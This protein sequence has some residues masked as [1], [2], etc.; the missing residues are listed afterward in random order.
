MDKR[1]ISIITVCYNSVGTIYRTIRSVLNQTYCNIEYIIID[2]GSTDGTVNIIKKYSNHLA[3]WVSEQDNG[4]YDAMNKGI[5]KANG[6]WILFLNSGDLLFDETIIADIA[7]TLQ[8]D[9]GKQIYCGAVQTVFN[10]KPGKVVYPRELVSPWYSPPHQGMFFPKKALEMEK[11]DLKFPILADRELYLRL[12]K[13]GYRSSQVNKIIAYYDLSGISSDGEK[14]IRIFQEAKR[15]NNLYPSH[16]KKVAYMK[17]CL[18][19]LLSRL[20]SPKL[21]SRLRYIK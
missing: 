6:D 21:I 11:Y 3:Y 15:I 7:E 10:K 19:L 5:D 9:I 16:G 13:K 1:K 4:I 17:A 20:I 2:G 18:K 8:N 12:N 14:A